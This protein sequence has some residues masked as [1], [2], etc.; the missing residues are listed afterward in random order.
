MNLAIT[1]TQNDCDTPPHGQLCLRYTISADEVTSEDGYGLIP[2][3]AVRITPSTITLSIDT[4]H[5]PQMHLMTGHGGPI[6]LTWSI[7][8]GL[9][10]PVNQ[11]AALAAATVQGSILGYAVPSTNVTA[12][13]LMSSAP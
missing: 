10:H 12:A 2:I 5:D 8:L 9:P 4:R 11:A 7:P 1:Q 6:S 13:V 3:S